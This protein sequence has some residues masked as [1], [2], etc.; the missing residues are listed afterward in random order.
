[1]YLIANRFLPGFFEIPMPS[2][3]SST[4]VLTEGQYDSLNP[5]ESSALYEK[6]VEY[7][8]NIREVFARLQVSEDIEVSIEM[9]LLLG[10]VCILVVCILV[11]IIKYFVK[12]AVSAF[13][14]VGSWLIFDP[15]AST[16]GYIPLNNVLRNPNMPNHLVIRA[17]AKVVS[18]LRELHCRNEVS[19][20][21]ALKNVFVQ[22]SKD[23]EL[24]DAKLVDKTGVISA[25]EVSKGGRTTPASDIY[26]L[27]DL[28]GCCLLLNKNSRKLP[29]QLCRLRREALKQDPRDR[30]SA[31][32]ASAYVEAALRQCRKPRPRLEL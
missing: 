16:K 9:Y 22:V 3:L 5:T 6:K 15:S 28:V 11:M 24:L 8:R 26:A 18:H 13:S 29:I 30:L 17:L 21:V 20:L 31:S 4:L 32:S 7:L 27:G 19:N 14:I 2:L 23:C 10:A 25:P 12:G 1:M